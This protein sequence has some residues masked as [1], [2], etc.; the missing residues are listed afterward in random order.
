[1][2]DTDTKA[3]E[4]EAK[5][6]KKAK[7][8]YVFTPFQAMKKVNAMLAEAGVERTLQGPMLYSYANSGKFKVA[9]AQ[10]D[11]DAKAEKP[12]QEVDEESFTEWAKAFVESA[13][14]GTRNTSKKAD[15]TDEA[16]DADDNEVDDEDE[17]DEDEDADELEDDDE[18]LDEAE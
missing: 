18:E 4:T 12:R 6:E 17:S 2:T 9:P 15:K 8:A 5:V 10:V 16:E 14:N 1:M 7:R 3:P 11:I 13:K